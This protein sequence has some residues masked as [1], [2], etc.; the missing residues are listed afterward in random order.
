MERDSAWRMVATPIG[1]IFR[2]LWRVS[3]APFIVIAIIILGLSLSSVSGPYL[4]SRLVDRMTGDGWHGAFSTGFLVYAVLTGLTFALQSTV[5]YLAAISAE[6]LRF[7][8]STSFFDRLLKKPPQF[9]VEHN[10]AEIQSAQMQGTQALDLVVQVGLIVLIPGFVQLALTLAILGAVIDSRIALIVLVYGL[11]VIMLT[12]F[13]NIWSRP[14]LETATNAG[15]QNAQLIG[16]AISSIETLRYFGSTNWMSSRFSRGAREVLT[17]WRRYCLKR[18]A[19]ASVYGVALALQFTIT[20]LIFLPRYRAGLVSVGD[21]VLFNTLLLQLNRPFE[22]VGLALESLMRSYV[23]LKPFARIWIS[24]EEDDSTPSRGKPLADRGC[25][26]FRDV[27]FTYTDGRGI[28]GV[29][30]VA[31]RGSIT[32]IAGESGAGKSTVLKLALKAVEPSS[33]AIRVDGVDLRKINRRDWYGAVGVVPQEVMLLNDTLE[34]N[35]ALGRPICETRLREAAA[36]AAILERIEELPDGFSTYV[37]ERGLKL[38]GGERQRIAIARALYGEPQFLFLDEASSA[39]DDAAEAGIM[40]HI[41][42]LAGDV[43]VLAIT[44]RKSAI[45]ETDNV[46]TIR[47][48]DQPSVDR[49]GVRRVPT[50]S[51]SHIG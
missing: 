19:Y 49:D 38:S 40:A 35:I 47:G 48:R 1:G 9:F 29:N 12:Y 28:A 18:I 46:I 16:N 31:E 21:V 24:P 2:D 36:K 13:S 51:A 6:N 42:K 3:R 30:F 41:R 33:G 45:C 15:Q 44:H 17:N 22:M 25:L 20:F 11:I 4:F 27:H 32:F 10:P 8:A 34:V 26:E 5:S 23:Q 43:T 39:L 7:I 50:E 14:H 37:G